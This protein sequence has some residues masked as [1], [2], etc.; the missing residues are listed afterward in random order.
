MACPK[1]WGNP[2]TDFCPEHNDKIHHCGNESAIATPHNC[3]CG[4]STF[5]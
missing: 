1:T 3:K 2:Q 5:G 4:N